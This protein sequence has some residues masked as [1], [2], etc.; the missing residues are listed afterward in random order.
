MF[1]E[2]FLSLRQAKVPVTLR[3]YLTLLGAM[4]KGIANY[5]VEKFY[6]LSRSCMVEATSVGCAP[7][8]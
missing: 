2:F 4:E 5:D 6:Y 7:A 3:E 8:H 1:N